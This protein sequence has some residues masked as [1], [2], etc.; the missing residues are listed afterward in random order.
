MDPL[1]IAVGATSLAALAFKA[2]RGVYDC[3][4]GIRNADSTLLQLQSEVDALVT[5]LNGIA[6]TF[7]SEGVVQLCRMQ[8]RINR[9]LSSCWLLSNHCWED[10]GRHWKLSTS[11]LDSVR[12]KFGKNGILQRSKR[13]LKIDLTSKDVEAVRHQIRSYNS[14]MQVTLQMV[15]M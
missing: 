4:D 13:A 10:V 7:E 6:A 8:G 3:V 9:S 5:G 11:M 1:S 14:A 12:G 2:G 15:A